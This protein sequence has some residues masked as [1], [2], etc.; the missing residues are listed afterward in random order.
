M[1]AEVRTIIKRNV[2][3]TWYMRGGI[4]YHEAMSLSP[5]EREIMEEFINDRF[6]QIKQSKTMYPVY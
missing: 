4:Q 3:L 6:E 5:V 1:Q 2:E